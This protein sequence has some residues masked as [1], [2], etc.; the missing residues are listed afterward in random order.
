MILLESLRFTHFTYLTDYI[1]LLCL[2]LLFIRILSYGSSL[3]RAHTCKIVA[4]KK[5]SRLLFTFYTIRT[6]VF[7]TPSV[8]AN[9]CHPSSHIRHVE[10][11]TDK[12]LR[13]VIPNL[14]ETE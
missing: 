6:C 9:T 13:I 1:G 10:K 12:L 3:L 8:H 4:D 11:S 14:Q 7:P 5:V 2:S